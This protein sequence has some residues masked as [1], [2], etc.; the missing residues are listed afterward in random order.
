[1]YHISN[2]TFFLHTQLTT[3]EMPGKVVE[4][5]GDE[6]HFGVLS[7]NQNNVYTVAVLNAVGAPVDSMCKH[8]R[9]PFVS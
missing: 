5:K 6:D 1:M 2:Y 9:F 4:V 3:Q 7:V 8:F